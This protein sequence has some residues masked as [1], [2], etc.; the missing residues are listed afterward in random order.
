MTRSRKDFFFFSC[1]CFVHAQLCLYLNALDVLP[2]KLSRKRLREDEE[3]SFRSSIHNTQGSNK[4]VSS[5]T[6]RS[7]PG[8]PLEKLTSKDSPSSVE[9]PSFVLLYVCHKHFIILSVPQTPHLKESCS[10]GGAYRPWRK[11]G[12]EF[13]HCCKKIFDGQ[14]ISKG[15]DELLQVTTS[16]WP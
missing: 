9:V 3:Q 5:N 15:L 16:F 10:V 14:T 6:E 4:S 13:A 1:L 12:F 8:L 2:A 11:K 7:G